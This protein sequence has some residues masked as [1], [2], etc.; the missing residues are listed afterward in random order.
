MAAGGTPTP[1]VTV[2]V[3]VCAS[4]LGAASCSQQTPSQNGLVSVPVDACITV[5]GEVQ[6]A[7]SAVPADGS[8]APSSPLS[9][10]NVPV[11]V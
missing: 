6:C 8:A 5:L 7:A 3:N 4:I 11:D 1:L 2:P 10:I 9:L